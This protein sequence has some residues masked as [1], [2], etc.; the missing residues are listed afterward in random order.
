MALNNNVTNVMALATG[1]LSVRRSQ[2]PGPSTLRNSSRQASSPQ[3]CL[4]TGLGAPR[5]TRDSRPR[6]LRSIIPTPNT[7][8]NAQPLQKER[9]KM[10]SSQSRK[11]SQLSRERKA[12][13]ATT[14]QSRANL[15]APPTDSSRNN[16]N[17]RGADSSRTERTTMIAQWSND[18]A[19]WWNCGGGI[20]HKIDYIKYTIKSKR[21]AILFIS[22]SEIYFHNDLGPLQIEGYDLI[23]SG[24]H[25]R[26]KA[27]VA[28]YIRQNL[29][30]K[31]IELPDFNYV[32]IIAF[33]VDDLT[34]VGL[35]RPFT[36]TVQDESLV[37]NFDR[38]VKCLSQLE[39]SPS[40]T[41]VVGGDFNVNWSTQSTLKDKLCDWANEANLVQ[42]V[43]QTT[44][45]RLVRTTAGFRLEESCIDHLFTSDSILEKGLTI[46]KAQP[47]DHHMLQ[48]T[49]NLTEPT[50]KKKTWI[51]DWRSYSKADLLTNIRLVKEN[52]SDWIE[53][54]PMSLLDRIT[55]VLLTIFEEMVPLRVAITQDRQPLN[56]K[57]EAIRKRRDR[58]LK[59][60]KKSQNEEHAILAKTFSKTLKRVVKKEQRRII[61]KKATTGN[62]KCFWSTVSKLQG[63]F[64]KQVT[65]LE[66]NGETVTDELRIAEAFATGFLDKISMLSTG[67]PPIAELTQPD[68][69]RMEPFNSDEITKAA[70]K[71]KAKK[72]HGLDGIPACI[73]K[74][75]MP[76]FG[77]QYLKIF[78]EILIKGLPDTWRTAV[79]NP[80]HKKGA[81]DQV[82]NYRPISNL[83]SLGKLF[84]K[85][86]L[87][88]L[89][90]YDNLVGDNQ[91]GFRTGYST[92]TA[93]LEIQSHLSTSMD[94][95]LFTAIYS[96]DMS[97]AFDLLRPDT[98][99][100]L[101]K[102]NIEP[103]LL[104][105]LCDFLSDRQFIVR[106]GESDS[107]IRRLDRGCVQGSV[108]GPALFS[109]YCKDLNS[110]LGD[111]I[112]TSYADDTYVIVSATSMCE[113]T[114]K[115]KNT[116]ENHFKFLAN[117]GMVVN[118]AKTEVMFMNKRGHVLPQSIT[119]DATEI[120]VQP[121][122]KVL[123]VLFDHQLS[124]SSQ[125]EVIVSKANKMASGLR[126]I[127]GSLT[128]D[129]FLK[130]ATA[131]Y[132]GGIYYGLPVWYDPLTIKLKKKLDVLHYK[133]LRIAVK[134]WRRIY[135]NDM[136]DLLD[137]A[138]PAA[139]ASYSMGSVF[140][141]T[142][143]AG[144]PRR[145]LE[146]INSNSY[147][148]RR[149]GKRRFYDSSSKRIGKQSI[150]NRIDDT[151]RHLTNEWTDL[152]T[153]DAIRIYLK[154]IFF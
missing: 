107:A 7:T 62:S 9:E 39:I 105:T 131:Q 101:M 145:L 111:N 87:A 79:V 102:G 81:M 96:L 138:K 17:P 121:T 86:V 116:M 18:I 33:K 66:I 48:L 2:L 44:R 11:N 16:K 128:Q 14:N 64:K 132:F 90:R 25:A 68:E 22:E 60:F 26:G 19:L 82:G 80:I 150:N 55:V 70:M 12:N 54:G 1:S 136:L 13:Q 23:L 71:M 97:A 113:L 127:R 46:L 83:S 21:P 61:Q 29:K 37:D 63:K 32:E 153:K 51:R 78:N 38:L 123:G 120:Q 129:Q 93:M 147:I 133:A 143:L 154:K 110:A 8:I 40:D 27:R 114:S 141:N 122:L 89:D 42:L 4:E 139:F 134:D 103:G 75:S 57:I 152:K 72:A 144:R 92:V 106:F 6:K 115:L 125:M 108:L 24:T 76:E 36:P 15:V 85:C 58:Y 3:T 146:M 28:A 148:I 142:M 67:Q 140:L 73:I 74:D 47:S 151:T 59:K 118:K 149:T 88:R 20:I 45:Q 94:K 49:I 126:V 84:E 65:S 10:I 77:D 119:V 112:V 100:R 53:N 109:A 34:I 130:V 69:S 124:W 43:N 98:F 137:R 117:L 95:G 135:P 30:Y 41:I 104:W 5:Y 50:P 35:Y 52:F 31:R 56:A 91:H 99:H